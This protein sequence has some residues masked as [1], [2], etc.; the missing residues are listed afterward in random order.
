MSN[1]VDIEAAKDQEKADKIL[2]PM[3]LELAAAKLALKEL[4][5]KVWETERKLLPKKEAAHRAVMRRAN[6]LKW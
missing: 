4:D 1:V 2:E 3:Y 6:D 5:R